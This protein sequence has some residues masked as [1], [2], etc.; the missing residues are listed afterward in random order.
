MLTVTGALKVA[1][2]NSPIR[3]RSSSAEPCC[4]GTMFTTRGTCLESGPARSL[5]GDTLWWLVAY[6]AGT[7]NSY[8]AVSD[9]RQCALL[10]LGP[11]F[12]S[13]HGWRVTRH[14][15][16]MHH[17]RYTR[18]LTTTRNSVGC[19]TANI[20]VPRQLSYQVGFHPSFEKLLSHCVTHRMIGEFTG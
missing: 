11:W 1:L 8:L 10:T 14:V 18:L 5:A 3:P 19:Q 12:C 17:E 4:S 2:L 6:M 9:R 15:R 20:F 13:D 7:R 16:M